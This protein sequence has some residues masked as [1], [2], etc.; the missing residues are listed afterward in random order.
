M[1][2]LTV[3][4]AVVALVTVFGVSSALAGEGDLKQ[5]CKTAVKIDQVDEPS[6][7]LLAK[8]R[9]TA[10]PEIADQ[11]DQAVTTFEEQGE[12]AFEDEAFI[13]LLAEIDQF[14][15][16]NCGYEVIDV[17]LQD[18][19]FD[20]VPGEIEKGTVAFNLTNEGTELHE[21][22]FIRLK[23]DAT[24]EDIL[25]LPADAEEHEFEEFGTEVAGGGFAFPGASDVALVNFKKT[26]NYVALCSI[27]VGT[28]PDVPDGGSG[29]PHFTEGMAAVFE[30]T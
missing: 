3:C 7:K 27:P 4:L 25:E 13:A 29:P 14:V 30:V 28:T 23:G 11:V 20:G 22:H 19:A 2:R 18:Y 26:G 9:D 21:I 15:V 12:A 5:F 8:F 24:L 16:D 10:P 1:R 17:T 6:E